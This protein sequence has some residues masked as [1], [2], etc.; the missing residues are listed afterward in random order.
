[1]ELLCWAMASPYFKV[2]GATP[3]HALY[4]H[5]QVEHRFPTQNSA[6]ACHAV[7]IDGMLRAGK[8]RVWKQW[9]HF[10]LGLGMYS[11]PSIIRSPMT[12]KFWT[13][14]R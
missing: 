13:L 8:L 1:M 9:A 12:S 10:H 6:I 14:L 4:A 3:K 11:L 2:L 5:T 7:C